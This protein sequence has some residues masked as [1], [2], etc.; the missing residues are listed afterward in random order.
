MSS[1]YCARERVPRDESEYDLIYVSAL[2]WGDGHTQR[3]WKKVDR[4]GLD[5]SEKGLKAYM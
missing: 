3:A 2:E 4:T 1:V 5:V